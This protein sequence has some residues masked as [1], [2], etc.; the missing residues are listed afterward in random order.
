MDNSTSS[1]FVAIPQKLQLK[2]HFTLVRNLSQLDL[3]A[4]VNSELMVELVN[5]FF[6][7]HILES[8]KSPISYLLGC[9]YILF[10]KDFI[11]NEYFFSSGPC[12]CTT[13]TPKN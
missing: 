6:A 5:I 12:H 8:L 1:L 4:P 7:A 2:Q 10:F 3:W 13:N 9:A 11:E